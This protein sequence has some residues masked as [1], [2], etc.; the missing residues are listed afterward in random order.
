MVQRII[1]STWP[2]IELLDWE[3]DFQDNSLKCFFKEDRIDRE[4]SWAGQGLQVW[5]QI[6][7]HLV[8]LRSSSMIVLDEPEINL[9][10]EKQ[11][12]LI[13]L[14]S[15]HHSGNALVAT[16]SVEL[17]NNVSVSHIFHVRKK[18]ASPAIKSTK[19][20]AALEL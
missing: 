3:R 14:L 6:A 16:H 17:M 9:H 11:N 20:R 12:D 10:P 15:D 19:N 5:F 13:R 8:R 2:S 1:A 18:E 4:I 7:T